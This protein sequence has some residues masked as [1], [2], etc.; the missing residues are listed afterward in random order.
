VEQSFGGNT[1]H[2]QTGATHL[3]FLYEANTHSE[4]ARSQ[5]RGI[6]TASCAQNDKVKSVLSHE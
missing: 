5:R 2:V 3:V 6:A 4:L 1:A